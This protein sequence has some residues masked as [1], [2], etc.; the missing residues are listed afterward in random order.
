MVAPL[1]A[2]AGEVV[3]ISAVPSGN[4]LTI[5]YQMVDPN[6]VPLVS[7]T[8]KP[9]A[10]GLKA[11]I[12]LG[13]GCIEGSSSYSGSFRVYPDYVYDVGAG[14]S[15]YGGTPIADPAAAGSLALGG[16]VTSASLCMA[17]IESGTAGPNPGPVSG[18]LLTLTLDG[19]GP[20]DVTVSADTSRGGIV[21]SG[22]VA[23]NLPQVAVVNVVPDCWTCD[24]QNLGN[25]TGDTAVNFADLAMLKTGMFTDACDEAWG[26]ALG[27]YNTCA[28]FSRDGHVNFAD[29]ALLKANMF[30]SGY[31]ACGSPVAACTP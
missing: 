29:L 11:D 31:T 21:A 16:T 18:T 13:C 30:S 4:N 22:A 6:G 17:R 19:I 20:L 8:D 26:T 3:A 14:Y 9:I 23:D 5:S 10:F 1:Y 15:F 7:P 2:A 28:D 12:T 25:G 24:G 27:Q